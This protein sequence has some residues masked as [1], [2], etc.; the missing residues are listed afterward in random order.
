MPSA[1]GLI[2]PITLGDKAYQWEQG[3]TVLGLSLFIQV[4]FF[5]P[6]SLSLFLLLLSLPRSIQFIKFVIIRAI[7]ISPSVAQMEDERE[8]G[9]IARY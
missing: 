5:R 2:L 4:F 6:F 8:L 3:I 1:Y 7:S 9:S